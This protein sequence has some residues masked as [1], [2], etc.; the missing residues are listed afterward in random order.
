MKVDYIPGGQNHLLSRTDPVLRAFVYEVDTGSDEAIGIGRR[1]RRYLSN[2]RIRQ[3]SQVGSRSGGQQVFLQ[4]GSVHTRT[5]SKNFACNGVRAS[6]IA[7][8]Y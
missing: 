7:R 8:I 5:V 1:I 4:L 6:V 2:Q 3:D